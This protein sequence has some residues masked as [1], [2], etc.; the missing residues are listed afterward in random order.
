MAIGS[1][2]AG[3]AF[4]P[5]SG[6]VPLGRRTPAST[7]AFDC[8]RRGNVDIYSRPVSGG[9]VRRLTRHPRM[10]SQPDWSPSRRSIAFVSKRRDGNPD[11]WIM[12]ASGRDAQDLTP[13]RGAQT[14]PAWSPNGRQI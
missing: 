4:A 9:S 13:Q 2:A 12:K 14:D 7:V 8:A 10:D 1:L 6:R 3:A 11:I 5:S